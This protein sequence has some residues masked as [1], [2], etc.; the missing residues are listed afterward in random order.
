MAFNY[1]QLNGG[2][3]IDEYR[4]IVDTDSKDKHRNLSMALV[5]A[6]IVPIVQS[7][8][9]RLGYAVAV[10]GS[11]ARDLDLLAAPW[12]D[13]AVSAEELAAAVRDAL[14]CEYFEGMEQPK[15]KPHGRL[16][17]S[18]RFVDKSGLIEHVGGPYIDLSV[19]PRYEE[20]LA[21]D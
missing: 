7:V 13:D 2:E 21:K 11:M 4:F 9:R 19:M 16:A 18:M 3:T 8:A 14:Y 15:Q 17:W 5:Y 1:V 10:H 6:A 12:T 20:N